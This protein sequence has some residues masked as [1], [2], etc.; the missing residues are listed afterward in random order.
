M[1]FAVLLNFKPISNTI[2]GYA[3]DHFM[4]SVEQPVTVQMYGNVGIITW[5]AHDT[6]VTTFTI[7]YVADIGET[8]LLRTLSG[9]KYTP[10]N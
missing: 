7:K 5:K 3:D 8:N 6:N 4:Q 10:I 1:V 2:E 9:V